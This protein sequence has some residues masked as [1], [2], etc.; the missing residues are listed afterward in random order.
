MFKK[1]MEESIIL[2]ILKLS[3][4]LKSRK[5]KISHDLGVSTQQWLI[6]LHLAYDQNIPFLER[7][8]QKRPL[9]SSELADSLHVTRPNITA[10]TN[11]LLEKDLIT[12]TDDDIDKRRKSLTLTEKG[13]ELLMELQVPREELNR[14]LFSHFDQEELGNFL[15]Y[16]NKCIEILDKDMCG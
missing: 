13:W 7:F 5:H 2:R 14:E 16:L 8:T 4:Q 1:R 6:L 10:I 9:L 11:V 15:E 3:D 12:Q